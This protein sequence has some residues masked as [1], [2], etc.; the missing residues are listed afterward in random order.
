MAFLDRITRR[1][2]AWHAQA[3]RSAQTV[4]QAAGAQARSHGVTDPVAAASELVELYSLRSRQPI[5][6]EFGG[7]A[8]HLVASWPTDLAY[9]LLYATREVK[10]RLGY[11]AVP[12]VMKAIELLPRLRVENA[13]LRLELSGRARLLAEDLDERAR[14]AARVLVRE[15]SS[16]PLRWATGIYVGMDERM[17]PIVAHELLKFNPCGAPI[18]L[19]ASRAHLLTGTGAL[20][21]LLRAL[22]RLVFGRGP[23][24]GE[25]R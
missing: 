16:V 10:P 21:A 19:G 6:R 7:V 8:F 20:R 13:T 17:K 11:D 4:M 5:W 12:P 24:P 3:T 18:L 22:S 1:G 15:L 25:R 23:D 9:V 14:A 2:R